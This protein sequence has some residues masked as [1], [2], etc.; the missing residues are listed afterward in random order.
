MAGPPLLRGALA[1]CIAQQG[2]QVTVTRP[3]RDYNDIG[4]VFCRGADQ[5]D[6]SDVDLFRDG[7]VIR[8]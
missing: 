8:S 1:V 5:G 6:A 7:L 3:V 2:E 4:V